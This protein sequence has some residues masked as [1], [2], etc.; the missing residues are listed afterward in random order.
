MLYMIVCVCHGLPY[1][2]KADTIKFVTSLDCR[3][4][5]NVMQ[6]S[7]GRFLLCAVH[8]FTICHKFLE[9]FVSEE[10]T[11]FVFDF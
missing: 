11:S 7:W 3:P 6:Y 10:T 2:P 4:V 8:I 5:C 9:I 1:Y